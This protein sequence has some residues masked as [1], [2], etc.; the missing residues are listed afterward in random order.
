ITMYDDE[1]PLELLDN[2]YDQ[3]ILNGKFL[4][5]GT[6]EKMRKSIFR[7]P[8]EGRYAFIK[9]NNRK[10]VGKEYVCIYSK[11]FEDIVEEV[12]MEDLYAYLNKK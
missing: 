9:L 4:H 8:K 10:L 2:D 7:L 6:I 1:Y 11:L 5:T 3:L 12:S